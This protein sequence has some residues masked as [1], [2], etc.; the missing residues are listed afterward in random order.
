VSDLL[1]PTPSAFRPFRHP[2][3]Q[4]LHDAL[5]R[6]KARTGTPTLEYT[7]AFYGDVRQ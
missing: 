6:K 4:G 7:D 1:S 3:L 2:W 5:D